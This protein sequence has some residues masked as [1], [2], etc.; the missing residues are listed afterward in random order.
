MKYKRLE[1][2][3]LKELEKE[4]IHFLASAQITGLDWEKMKIKEAEKAEELINVFSDLVYE[5]VMNKIMYL[6]YRDNR[7]L[8]IFHF[9]N[10][11]IVL[12]GLRVKDN[13]MMDLFADNVFEQWNQSSA[14]AVNIIKTEKGYSKD[15]GLEAFE[16]IQTGC[17]ITDDKLFKVI[18]GML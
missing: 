13:N 8:N 5:K 6:E 4:F 15:R 12:I 18:N 14:N 7:S 1:N 11:K 10:D 17:F 16:L 9:M 3:E 2:N